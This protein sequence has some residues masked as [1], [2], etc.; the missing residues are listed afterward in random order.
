MGSVRLAALAGA[1]VIFGVQAAAAADLAPIVKAPPP[2]VEFGGWYLRGDIGFSNERVHEIRFV[3]VDGTVPVQNNLTSGFD[4]AG[5]FDLGVGYQF[6]SWLRVDVT[7][8]YRGKAHF[9]DVNS[10]DQGNGNFLAQSDFASKSEW[11]VLANVYADL[12]TWW[13]VTPFIGAGIGAADVI[14]SNFQDNTV[15]VDSRNFSTGKEKWNFAWALHA[16]L[17]YKVTPNFTVELAYQYLALGDATSGPMF[18][19][20]GPLGTPEGSNQFH[21]ITSHDLTLGVRWMFA[22]PPPPEPFYPLVRKG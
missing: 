19:G 7:G 1:A 21:R 17:A 3:S 9:Q 6:N 5:V 2:V 14:I 18:A 15:V 12:G 22:A 20:Y 4:S 8:Q 13:C 11:V 10:V 16:G